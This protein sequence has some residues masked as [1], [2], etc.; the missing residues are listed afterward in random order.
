[1]E[2]K[3]KIETKLER[4]DSSEMMIIGG[5]AASSVTLL[6][7]ILSV[8]AKIRLISELIDNY[9]PSFLKGYKEAMNPAS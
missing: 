1:M 5:A 4:L 6:D 2:E 9:V 8:I 7:K 3:Q